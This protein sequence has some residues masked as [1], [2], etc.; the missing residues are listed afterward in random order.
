M[1]Q[2]DHIKAIELRMIG[3]SYNEIAS[4]LDVG[5]SSLS[6][7]LRNLKLPLEAVKI[8]EKKNLLN[9]TSKS[10]NACKQKIKK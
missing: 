10:M 1:R 7:W 4:D 9:I 5:K 6:Y 2:L 8:L 3:K